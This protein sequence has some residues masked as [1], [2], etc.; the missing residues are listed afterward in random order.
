MSIVSD[1]VNGVT[2][3]TLTSEV[4]VPAS[5]LASD[6]DPLDG[7][8][9]ASFDPGEVVDPDEVAVPP[10]AD[11]VPSGDPLAPVVGVEAPQEEIS[12]ADST[13]GC[14][15]DNAQ[16]VKSCLRMHYTAYTSGSAYYV[17]V[18][19]YLHRWNRLD[20]QVRMSKAF[21]RAG[22]VGQAKSGT[23]YSKGENKTFGTPVSD[24]VYSHK[25]SWAGI[26]INVGG[27][28]RFQAANNEVTIARGT[29]TWTLVHA[30]V[31]RGSS[32]NW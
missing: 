12:D 29:R 23:F 25:P 15:S 24:S 6:E 16:V 20:G 18:L 19:Q 10:I 8:L 5:A 14:Q 28:G 1:T 22:V 4:G 3:W 21:A 31:Y 7:L 30:T 26:D 17:K 11:L 2:N 9:N 13:G 27:T 32:P